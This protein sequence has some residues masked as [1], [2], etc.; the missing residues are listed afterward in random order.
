MWWKAETLTSSLFCILAFFPLRV[1]FCLHAWK[2]I[3]PL[4]RLRSDGNAHLC[5]WQQ[6][7]ADP[8]LPEG[9]ILLL[10][11]L[12][13]WG[14]EFL[15]SSVLKEGPYQ[16]VKCGL[17][18]MFNSTKCCAKYYRNYSYLTKFD[19]VLQ[20][21]KQSQC[22]NNWIVKL[23]SLSLTNRSSFNQGLQKIVNEGP[24]TENV[25]MKEWLQRVEWSLW[26]ALL[27]AL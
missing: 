20:G 25:S 3:I 13:L 1:D 10:S 16:N 14:L 23:T 15:T 22:L 24:S 12:S 26:W 2:S 5:S 21:L 4:Q 6:C 17:P 8:W 19:M 18:A 7:H 9:G 27:Y 11:F